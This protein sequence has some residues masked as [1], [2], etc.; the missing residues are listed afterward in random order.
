M[1]K[2]KSYA[3]RGK[4]YKICSLQ[5][6]FLKGCS[7][8]EKIQPSFYFFGMILIVSLGF[9]LKLVSAHNFHVN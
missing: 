1:N 8:G 9:L 3:Q 7:E 6:I 2:K 5:F 4:G